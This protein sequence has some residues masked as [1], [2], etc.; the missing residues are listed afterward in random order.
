MENF[1]FQIVQSEKE[2]S[3]LSETRGMFNDAVC[4]SVLAYPL[5]F[6]I[7]GINT[8]AKYCATSRS[9]DIPSHWTQFLTGRHDAEFQSAFK[10]LP[11]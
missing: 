11:C 6:I 2:E 7:G 5:T 1:A 3:K 9:P 4:L 10:R 8:Y